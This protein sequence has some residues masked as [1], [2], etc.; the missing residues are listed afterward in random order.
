MAAVTTG[1]DSVR[2]SYPAIVMAL[3]NFSC[4]KRFKLNVAIA[5]DIS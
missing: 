3:V 5:I 2:C 1:T 4:A